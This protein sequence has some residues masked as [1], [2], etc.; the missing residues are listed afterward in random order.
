[1]AVRSPV[2]GPG[3]VGQ[4]VVV[5]QI[6]PGRAADPSGGPAFTD[7]LGELIAWSP[8]QLSVRRKD[9]TV[10]IVEQALVATA[11][12]GAAAARRFDTGSAQTSSSASVPAVGI[13]CS[14]MQLGE[15]ILR[16][17]GGFTGRANSVLPVGSP[18]QPIDNAIQHVRDFYAEHELPPLAQVIVGSDA[19]AA[20]VE[21]RWVVRSA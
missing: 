6:V 14:R 12:T 2:L 8:T 9:G 7:V 19:E 1:M 18:G 21:R 17:S 15:W 20:F 4:R 11:K 13:R 3:L 5:R 16:A 10:A